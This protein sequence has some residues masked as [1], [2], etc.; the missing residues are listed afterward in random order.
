MVRGTLLLN[1]LSICSIMLNFKKAA[2]YAKNY[3][4]IIWKGLMISTV[5]YMNY[6]G[7]CTVHTHS[8]D[9]VSHTCTSMADMRFMYRTII[10]L[11]R[12]SGDIPED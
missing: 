7:P 2:Y 3:A 11:T 9:G 1:F 5:Q 6:R 8:L 12:C 10:A 4:G